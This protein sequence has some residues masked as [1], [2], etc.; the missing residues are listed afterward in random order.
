MASRAIGAMFFSA[1]GGAWLG[2]W[3][4]S[5]FGATSLALLL[6]AALSVVLLTVSYLAYRLNAPAL[7]E[8]KHTAE[9]KHR[10]RWFNI[11]NAAQWIATAVIVA[12][13]WVLGY[14]RLA[15]PATVFIV[16]LHF[17]PLA[18]LFGYAPHYVTGLSLMLLAIVYPVVASNGAESGIGALG[19]GLIL[20][21]SAIYAIATLRYSSRRW[22]Q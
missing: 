21:A 14:G 16:G 20:W 8:R 15:L 6:I 7:R 1:F 22:R 13:L 5:E 2:L 4:Y 10:A 18:R 3:A 11:I 17:L 12:L 19:A 9:A